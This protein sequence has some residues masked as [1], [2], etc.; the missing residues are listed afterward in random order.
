MSLSVFLLAWVSR[1]PRTG[2]H[3]LHFLALCR[4]QWAEPIQRH[5]LM[6]VHELVT[7]V[8]AEAAA[9]LCAVI[10]DEPILYTDCIL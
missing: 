7:L 6:Q 2:P 9:V 8:A 3:S 10:L 1:I 5:F 4:H